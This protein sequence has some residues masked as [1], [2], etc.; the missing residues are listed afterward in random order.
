MEVVD[1]NSLQ[2]VEIHD[3]EGRIE[4]M[5]HQMYEILG[6]RKQKTNVPIIPAQTF[7]CLM[8]ENCDDGTDIA[9]SD[10]L[11]NEMVISVANMAP[12]A[13]CSS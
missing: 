13:I 4:L 3:E 9:V 5:S 2:I 11:P 12:F 1:W 7:D 10:V 6:F 8:D